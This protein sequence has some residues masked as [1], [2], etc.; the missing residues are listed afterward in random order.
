MKQFLDSKETYDKVLQTL[1]KYVDL[2]KIK[3]EN[4][5]AGGSV[6]NILISMVHGGNPVINDIDVYQR[7]EEPKKKVKE[8]FFGDVTE[9]TKDMWYPATFINNDGLEIVDDHYGRVFLSESGARMR[10]LNHSRN[11]IINNISYIYED[12]THV[13]D[14]SKKDKNYVIIEGFDLNCC[15]AGLDLESEKIVYTP[16]FL[17]FLETKQLKVI[18]PCSPIQT[19]IRIFKKIADLNCH[20][21][22]DHEMRF[23]TVAFKKFSNRNVTKIIGPET[24]VKYDKLKDKVEKYFVLRPVE[25]KDFDI[26]KKSNVKIPENLW[27][28]D[29]VLKFDIL[30]VCGTMSRL[31]RVWDLVFSYRK[32]SEQDKINKIFYK[33]VFLNKT[34]DEDQ[35]EQRIWLGPN[36]FKTKRIYDSHRFTFEMLLAKKDYHKCNFT[37]QHVDYIDAFC[38]E[39]YGMRKILKYTNKLEETYKIIRFIKSL[40]KK[41][42]DWFIGSLETLKWSNYKNYFDGNLSFDFILK[43][44]NKEKEVGNKELI[45]KVELKNFR[46]KNNVKELVTAIQ[47]RQEGKKMGHCVGGYS[48]AISSGNSRIFH[49]EVDG[50][51]STVE[52]SVPQKKWYR[53][54]KEEKI[55]EVYQPQSYTDKC[56]I[57]FDNIKPEVLPKKNFL[58]NVRQHS[59]RYPEKGNLEPNQKNKKIVSEL[60]SYLNDNHLPPNYKIKNENP[61]NVPKFI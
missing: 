49:I 18:N 20:C 17:E 6:S 2:D 38:L 57:I 53:D 54:G 27:S 23:L 52:I 37:I 40:T 30:E 60:L 8:S 55:L 39:H 56:V 19:S 35:W 51:G 22:I 11:G 3:K 5:I 48:N 58:F 36:E 61:F 16:E 42:G 32:K 59:G 7:T 29:A 15:K 45:S 14:V 25:P 47:L 10:V 26:S 50:I 9:V 13:G 31:K 46:Y 28:Y 34:S 41:E 1:K 44:F 12:I 43:V 24:K 4:F 33:N 21:H